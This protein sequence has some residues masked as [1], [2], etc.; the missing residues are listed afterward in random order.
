MSND[1]IHK[2]LNFTLFHC[3]IT[4]CKSKMGDSPCVN[5][6]IAN[7]KLPKFTLRRKISKIHDE[8]IASL[9][10]LTQPNEI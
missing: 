2:K 5:R 1:A 8:K 7:A 10:L 4:H 6:K 9:K 3:P